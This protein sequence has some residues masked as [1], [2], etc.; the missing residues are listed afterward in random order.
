M[1]ESRFFPFKVNT[2]DVSQPELSIIVPI[3]NESAELPLLLA[4][5]ER[6]QQVDFELLFVDG[7]SSDGG[8]QWLRDRQDRCS[9]LLSVYDAPKGRARQLN[10]GAEQAAAEWLLFLHVDSRFGDPLALRKALD[11]LQQTGSCNLAGHFAL[12]F[13]RT[14]EQ[15][16]IGYYFY[17]WKARTG[18][19]ETI[20]GDQ[21]FLLRNS[22]YRQLG[23]FRED[24]PVMEDTDFAERLRSVGQWQLL[25]AEIST[26]ARRFETEGLW[27]RQLL[28]ALIMCFRDIGWEQFFTEAG[29]VYRHQ[30]EA[31]K[32]QVRP[33]FKLIGSL[34]APLG[35]GAAWRIWWQ[36]GCYVR[37]H[38]WQLT[39]A[40]DARQ[41]FKCKIPVGQGQ[42][43]LSNWTQ[44][45]YD[46]L[47]D[48]PL[49]RV[50]ATMLLRL[51]FE[52]TCLWLKAKEPN[53]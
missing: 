36:S 15:P 28:G 49:G 3:L 26:S 25:P 53:S 51:W 46:L 52:L 39:F 9:E 50:V 7:G 34:L 17:E 13:R 8:A 24:L 10:F 27:Q 11:F 22:F 38:A 21:G 33:F 12:H 48:N 1:N 32:L 44:P 16:S 2:V 23:G 29:N 20:H 47:T 31:E 45:L 4:D 19:P 37:R 6:Q 14:S 43:T 5:L 35:P 18:R 42:L 41:A 40:Y 30:S